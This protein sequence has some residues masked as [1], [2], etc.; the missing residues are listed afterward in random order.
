MQMGYLQPGREPSRRGFGGRRRQG[1]EPHRRE[2]RSRGGAAEDG[3]VLR[4]TAG[5]GATSALG[6]EGRK[7]AAAQAG[8]LAAVPGAKPAGGHEPVEMA[9]EGKTPHRAAEMGGT[10]AVGYEAERRWRR[11]QRGDSRL[12][13][14][15]C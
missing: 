9:V 5:R 3:L 6:T 11:L 14:R 7:G 2:A 12:K 8:T 4:G 1:R 10:S 13:L 15:Q